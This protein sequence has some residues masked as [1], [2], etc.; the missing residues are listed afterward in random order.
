VFVASL[1]GP[2]R[3]GGKYRPAAPSDGMGS[4]LAES[5][6]EL[7]LDQ[8]AADFAQRWWEQE[9]TGDYHVGSSAADE[10]DAAGLL[11]SRADHPSN[12]EA[13]S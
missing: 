6:D 2:S 4:V 11:P 7:D 8:G 12:L 5:E 13:S 10:L 9:S 1:C 3:A